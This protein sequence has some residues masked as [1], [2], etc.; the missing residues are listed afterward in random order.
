M[1]EYIAA[2]EDQEYILIEDRKE[3]LLP[4]NLGSR[5]VWF[6]REATNNSREGSL[7]W[8]IRETTRMRPDGILL[9]EII[10]DCSKDVAKITNVGIE[11]VMWTMHSTSARQALDSLVA[12][13]G[14]TDDGIR[15]AALAVA[16]AVDFVVHIDTIAGKHRIT[17]IIQVS[18]TATDS[19][20]ISTGSLYRFDPSNGKFLH[21][22]RLDESWVK[23][24]TDR[25]GVQA[26]GLEV[27]GFPRTR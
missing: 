11:G 10:G 20:I 27:S 15:G 2:D 25:P 23:R 21:T 26:S 22:G 7:G 3:I 5:R 19:A 14:A 18:N 8:V 17:E 6:D 1:T 4:D 9:G 13:Y 16:K 12:G 24:I